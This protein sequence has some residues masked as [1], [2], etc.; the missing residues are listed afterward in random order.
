MK[1]EVT[2]EDFLCLMNEG[3]TFLDG[4]HGGFVIGRRHSEGGIKILHEENGS[5][6]C[7]ELEIEGGE[8]IVNP[9]ATTKFKDRLAEINSYKGEYKELTIEDTK[10]LSNVLNTNHPYDMI[11]LAN[12]SQYIINRAAT[13][14]YIKE[15]DKMNS[16]YNVME[17]NQ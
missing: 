11:L 4:I 6:Y 3:A 12:Y 10:K 8:Y 7:G 5:F 14:K 15:L 13:S 1:I 17:E 9:I 16:E 2:K